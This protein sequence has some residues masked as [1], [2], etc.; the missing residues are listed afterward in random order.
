MRIENNILIAECTAYDFKGEL[1]RKK[2]RSWLKSVSAFADT[3]GGTLFLGVDNDA[4][5]VGVANPQKDLEFISE[6]IN[7]HLDP[8][9]VYS[10]N[11]VQT[12]E[13]RIILVLQIP[14]GAQTP[15]YLN[16][17]GKRIAYVR[18]GNESIPATPHE[19]FE[20]VLRGSNLSWD[21]LVSN[22]LREKH[23]FSTLER[24]YN[25]RS[26][27]VWEEGLLSSFGLVTDDGHLTNAGLLFADRSPIAQ[28]RVFCTKWNGTVKTD[29]V[30]DS[31]YQGNL[32]MLLDMAKNFIKA[33]TALRWYKL[34]D[35]RL[36]LPE[37]A[38]RAIEEMCVNHLIHR[39]YSELG[40]E[41]AINIYDDRIETTSP[42]GITD[43]FDPVRLE[44]EK[45]TSKRRNPVIA[46]VFSQL[47]Y[48]EKR[49]SGLRKIQ[50]AT[51]LL[52]SYKPDRKPIFESSREFFYTTIPNVNYGMTDADFE[53]LTRRIHPENEEF[54]QRI[55]PEKENFTQ[56]I[57]PEEEA[58]TSRKK[59][60][61]TAQAI[62]DAIVADPKIT[63]KGLAELIGKSED[64]VNIIWHPCKRDRL[65]F[66]SAR[67]TAAI[68]K[69]C[70]R[71]NCSLI[72]M[73]TIEVVAA[74]IRRGD[75]VFAT[76]RG[77]GE[78]KDYWEYPGGK[79]EPGES[80]EAA[81]VREIREELDTEIN[82]DK[83]LTTIEWDY[84]K[85][86][87]KM[88]CFM[89]SLLTEAL[90]L[91]EHEDARWLSAAMLHSVN[92]LPADYQLIPLIEKELQSD[93]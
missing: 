5:V 59:I 52:P 45:I 24:E 10:L 14:A 74:I 27:S 43:G 34:T 56:R 88:H 9:P 38:E 90:H 53:K 71:S 54:T 37:Y 86:H 76:Q 32:L 64:T 89:C 82:V 73:K 26:G 79:V 22:D 18:R 77:Y 47:R 17:Y 62:I 93:S 20:L 25:K 61:K 58:K 46:E 51:A 44:P 19:L 3:D 63:R 80:P 60:G 28:S 40:S 41:V 83:F 81:L 8:V 2:I 35:Y 87:L 33:N 91:N 11:P 70:S 42:G 39:D 65:S 31:E 6:K 78:W 16:L 1:E 75:S 92:W 67:T 50:D 69:S 57:D 23:T 84:P 30:N 15:Y 85:F 68:G 7:A 21:S 36:N 49:G 4:R 66:M 48:M 13:G 29:A 12:P 72:P 55:D